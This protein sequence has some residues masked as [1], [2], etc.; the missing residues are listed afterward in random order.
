[1]CEDGDFTLMFIILLEKS[2]DSSFSS[3]GEILKLYFTVIH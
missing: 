1:M 2:K 3:L